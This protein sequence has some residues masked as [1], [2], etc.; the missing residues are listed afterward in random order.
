MSSAVRKTIPNRHAHHCDFELD[1][2][3]LSLDENG[4]IVFTDEV[5]ADFRAGLTEA[6]VNFHVDSVAA[7]VLEYTGN[8]RM[9]VRLQPVGVQE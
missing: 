5:W 9:L 2:T 6:R 8:G 1:T 7:E 4:D 3:Q